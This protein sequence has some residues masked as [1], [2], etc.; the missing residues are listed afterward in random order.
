[1][2][3]EIGVLIGWGISGKNRNK[4]SKIKKMRT[5]SVL[6][7]VISLALSSC[8]QTNNQGSTTTD[9]DTMVLKTDTAM[10]H[11]QDTSMRYN[12]DTSMHK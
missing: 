8:Q 9:P 7:L 3:S 4:I 2:A 11:M 5:L 6:I 12:T 1:M 10:N